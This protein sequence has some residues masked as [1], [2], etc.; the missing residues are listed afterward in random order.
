MQ[1]EAQSNALEIGSMLE[2]F[3]ILQILGAGG[4]GITY[5]VLD[6]HLDTPMVIK[7]Y[8]PSQ[9]ASRSNKTTVTYTSQDKETFEWGL[10]RFIEEAKLLKKFD[11]IS[12][13]KSERLIKANNTAYFVMKFFEGE[14]LKSYLNKH[15][16][17]LFT[18][19][20]ILFVMMPI[21]EALKAVHAEGFLHRDVAPDNIFLRVS[22]PPM[23]IDFGASRN[24][25]GVK[26][27]TISTIIKAGYSPV[28]QYTSKSKQDETT[29]LYAVS[30]VLYEI[31]TN[32]TPPESTYRQTEVFNDD[33]DP[34]ED[35]VNNYKDRFELSFLE[36]IARGLSIRQKDRI[37]T[38]KE[39]Q[40]GL[41]R[42]E[43]ELPEDSTP[44]LVEQVE[45]P[46][47]IGYRLNEFEILSVLYQGG[48][49]I[50]YKVLDTNINKIMVIAE[51][52]MNFSPSRN[53]DMN[54]VPNS[55]N[56]DTFEWGVMRFREEVRTLSKF[57]HPNIIKAS[58]IFELNNT[59]YIVMEYHEG[60]TL[61]G[62]LNNNKN[63]KL[64]QDEILPIV[65]PVLN[66][67]KVIHQKGYLYRDIASDTI[68]LCQD[69]RPILIDFGASGYMS[70]DLDTR[71]IKF[72]YSPPEQY[73]FNSKQDT[74]TD[75]YALSALIYEMIAGE[76][77]PESELR[78]TNII[79]GD[80][81]PLEDITKNS[82]YQSRFSQ[83]FLET[84]KKG[85]NLKQ[86]DRIQSVEEFE[87]G[88]VREEESYDES[89]IEFDIGM[90]Q[91]SGDRDYQNDYYETNINNNSALLVLSD[92]INSQ[93]VVKAFRDN[94]D[95]SNSNIKEALKNALLKANDSI[96]NAD[97]KEIG[98]TIIA[99]YI[100][101][102]IL[103][104][105]SVGN[106]SL[107][108][109]SPYRLGKHTIGRLNSKHTIEELLQKQYAHGEITQED[110]DKVPNKHKLT[111]SISGREISMI[112]SGDGLALDSNDVLILATDGVDTLSEEEIKNI[113]LDNRSNGRVAIN[114]L[115][116]VSKKKS[117][118]Q[119]NASI[120]AI[121]LKDKKSKIEDPTIPT[122]PPTDLDKKSK[123]FIKRIISELFIISKK[124]ENNGTAIA[125]YWGFFLLIL[126]IINV[127]IFK[128]VIKTEAKTIGIILSVESF[129]YIISTIYLMRKVKKNMKM[130]AKYLFI[131]IIL[132]SILFPVMI[133]RDFQLISSTIEIFTALILSLV[134]FILVIKNLKILIDEILT[135]IFDKY[136]IMFK[137]R[138]GW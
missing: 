93:K 46:L 75:F 37:Q 17:R 23:L 2:E 32:T 98:T 102:N 99:I 19:E 78:E 1:E 48:F 38:I 74:T 15:K 13:V 62:Y 25:L 65:L 66:A 96:R 6:T 11:H 55:E 8:M 14:T 104:W 58:R 101:R 12:V 89:D 47:P 33:H 77:S 82:D 4:F 9:F 68:F 83:S 107:L 29:D 127:V 27:Q 87:E 81:D 22:K 60:Q 18:K 80:D 90:G 7:E 69:N 59:A 88:L 57:N 113:V 109:I 73:T 118:N 70:V 40:E 72:G 50:T 97:N 67:L 10:E 42:E 110:I 95:K 138:K 41:V 112:D 119:D 30:A 84:V 125:I 131:A 108:K 100:N 130:L 114:I 134:F 124:K 111:S 5:K 34:I 71:T 133:F 28:E 56:S 86:K 105:I 115:D 24:A 64:T 61:E 120:I 121:S 122:S 79:N 39:F 43:D 103:N 49:K 16:N 106:S 92:G 128:E 123:S 76:K 26:S 44:Q 31:I 135:L 20:E 53:I 54:I 63:H 126:F 132:A 45:D 136:W 21:I 51:Y 91:T 94:F 35:I 137:N 36:T 129:I 52:V 3:K 116:E 117:P 85:L